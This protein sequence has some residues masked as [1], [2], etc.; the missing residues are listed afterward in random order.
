MNKKLLKITSI[1]IVCTLSITQILSV[2][3]FAFAK[4][5]YDY[6]N[7]IYGNGI[8]D[9]FVYDSTDSVVTTKT[10]IPRNI[11]KVTGLYDISKYPIPLKNTVENKETFEMIKLE[12]K[13]IMDKVEEDIKN[14][15]LTKHKAADGQFYGSVP[16]DALGVEKKVYV[17]TN[18]KGA[19]SLAAYVPAG[20]IA[21]VTLNE[22]ALNYAKKGKVK[23]SVG[24]TMVD[25]EEYEHNKDAE[26]RMPYLGKTFSVSQSETKVGTPFGGMVYIEIDDSV[27]SGLNFE[28]DV[29]GVVDAPYFDL[30]KTTAEEWAVSKNAPGVFAEI[31]TPYLRFVLPS[32]FIREIENPHNAALFWTNVSALSSGIMAQQYR[33]KPMTLTFDPYITAGIAYASVGSWTCNL[34]PEWGTSAL[35]YDAIMKDGDW[36]TIHEINHHYQRRY[37]NYSD[38]WGVGP[39]FSEITNNALSTVSYILYTNIAAS[40]SEEGTNDW[41]KVADPYSSLKQQIYEGDE[42]YKSEPNRGNF[43]YSTFAHEIGPVNFAKVVKSTYDGGTFNGIDIPAYDYKLESEGNKQRN[44]RFDDLAYRLCVAAERDYTWYMQTELLWPLKA[45]T[46]NKIKS[47]KYPQVIPV[48]SVY[49]MGEVGRETGRPFYVPSSGYVFDFENSLVSPG[50]V[51]VVKVS[52]PKYGKLTERSDGKYDYK[53]SSLMPE[54]AKDEFILTVNVEK[55]GISHETKL[56]CTIGVDYN[57]S[58]VEKFE[59]TKWDIHDALEALET[60]KPYGTATSIGMKIYSD[61]GNKL[62]RSK[63]YFVLEESGEYEFQAFG[64]DSAAFDLHLDDGTNYRSLTEVYVGNVE[65]AQKHSGSTNFTVNLQANKPYSYTLVTNNIDGP[66]WADVNIRKTSGDTSWRLINKVYSNLDDVGKTTDRSFTM[67]EPVYVRP[68]VL[69]SGSETLVNDIKVISTPK[70][71]EPN[72]DQNSLKEGDPNSIVD[73]DISTYFHSSYSNDKTPFPHEYIFDLGGEKSFNNLE[74]FTRRGGEEPGVI[75]DYEIYVADEYD[76]DNTIWR[77]IAED[78]KRG[79][80]PKASSDLKIP[81]AQTNAKYLK[82]KALNNRGHYDV[83]ILAEVRLSTATNVKSVIAQNSSLI[84]YKGDWT[85]DSNG[86][87]VNGATYNTKNGQ[88][89]YSF[90]GR[91]SNIYVTKAVDVEIRINGGKWNKK[92]LIGS[93][94][95]PSITLDMVTEGKYT[96]EVRTIGQEIA[97]NM[98]STD[99]IFYKGEAPVSNPPAI[100]GANKVEIKVGEVDTFDVMYGVSYTDDKDITGLTIN[101]SGSIDKPSAGTNEDYILIYSVTDSDGN[102]G[103]VNR[104][105]TVTNQIPVISGADD[106]TIKK[107]EVID[108]LQGVTATDKEDGDI[109]KNIKVIGAI[110]ADKEESY[111]LMYQ[112]IDNDGNIAEKSRVVVVENVDEDTPPSEDSSSS[113]NPVIDGAINDKLVSLISGTG[114]IEDPVELEFNDISDDKVDSL[115]SDVKKLNIKIVSLEEKSEYT[116][117]TFVI[118][119]NSNRI[120]ANEEETYI[121]LKVKNEYENIVNK[122]VKFAGKTDDTVEDDNT[123]SDVEN[124]TNSNT[125]NDT[126]NNANNN[127]NN[128]SSNHTNNDVSSNNADSNISNN[129][130]SSA[131]NPIRNEDYNDN[132]DNYVSSNTDSEKNHAINNDTESNTSNDSKDDA[133]NDNA[134][135]DNDDSVEDNLKTGNKF[136]I[137]FIGVAAIFLLV[138]LKA[139]S[140]IKTK[141]KKDIDR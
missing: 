119:E 34:P 21:A 8:D 139:L 48:Q 105:I 80:N 9:T 121:V 60:T 62:A 39:E 24:M 118:F 114:A 51:S 126:N 113:L 35:D 19:H 12:N 88:F 86:A 98:I 45:E 92:R 84:Q 40:R 125:G 91:E 136:L 5:D 93:L 20:E 4:K 38:E 81:L 109:T 52:Q 56:N 47:L 11:P 122:L 100:I 103:T 15:T 69:A 141:N 111:N 129:E 17:N 76:D 107:G 130:N 133:T 99:G 2:D 90:E 31:R 127:A 29:K 22:E 106:V 108:L 68:P 33:T 30:G 104:V 117:V 54:N 102:I 131:D 82:I 97:L 75:G 137:P 135:L 123:S 96:V 6:S 89:M 44:D 116:R 79:N 110:D 37:Y 23:I 7:P 14:G 132:K 25:A 128:N 27:P 85:K 140:K 49:G 42:Y 87:F 78:D 50:D 41:N 70:G 53:P 58:N 134:N 112:V 63:G 124:N 57:S 64:D 61:D 120:I 83:T 95:E 73:G 65:E 101:V 59:I 115:L 46:V 26:N 94:R 10:D 71:V 43:M 36:G 28:V 32:K 16:D 1:L 138:L 72:E 55:D 67:P 18:A 66:G 74:I 3:T 13:E 77:K